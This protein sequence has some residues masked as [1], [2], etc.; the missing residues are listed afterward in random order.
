MG[1]GDFHDATFEHDVLLR[2]K[3]TQETTELIACS[4]LQASPASPLGLQSAQT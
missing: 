1:L 3:G 4:H 2:I